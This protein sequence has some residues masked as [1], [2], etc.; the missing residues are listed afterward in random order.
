MNQPY[1]RPR[2]PLSRAQIAEL[3]RKRRRQRWIFCAFALLLLIVVITVAVLAV[4]SLLPAA[5]DDTIGEHRPETLTQ[6][7]PHEEEEETPSTTYISVPR[8]AIHEGN[9]ILVNRTYAC[10][11]SHGAELVAASSLPSDAYTL[12]EDSLSIDSTTLSALHEWLGAFHQLYPECELVLREAYRTAEQQQSMYDYYVRLG[13]KDYADQYVNPVGYSEHQTGL[14]VDINYRLANGKI[15]GL[16][17]EGNYAW[18][19]ENAPNYG[20]ILRYPAD[21][22]ALTGANYE[23]WHFRYVGVPH[24]IA[25]KEL[26]YCMEQYIDYVTLFSYD[27]N[28]LKVSGPGGEQYEIYYYQATEDEQQQVPIP[29]GTTNYTIEGDNV[30]GFVVT[31]R[32][33]AGAASN[34]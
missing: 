30:Q 11:E 25:M 14:A 33:D 31:I 10:P 12:N 23:S 5:E 28:H 2:K 19:T 7:L 32:T 16:T 21:K 13:G 26:D 20:F 4:R 9:L 1:Q 17:T 15:A 27:S 3:K 18:V 22:V 8:S 29:Y 6:T 24:A 34:A